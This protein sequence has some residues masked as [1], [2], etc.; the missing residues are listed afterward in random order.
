MASNIQ[1]SIAASSARRWPADNVRNHGSA[2]ALDVPA[3]S[4]GR[5]ELVATHEGTR[6]RPEM[7]TLR[8]VSRANF[9]RYYWLASGS[10]IDWRA[11]LKVVTR[12]RL[13]AVT[14]MWTVDQNP[15][16]S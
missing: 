15:T 11:E 8:P 16:P 7:Q 9:L 10:E 2:A 3:A 4:I 1:P 12:D 14:E 13:L 5:S 6:R